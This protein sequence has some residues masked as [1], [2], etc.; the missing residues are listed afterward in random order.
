[1]KQTVTKSA[2]IDAFRNAGREDNF[3]YEGLCALFDW[4]EE[5]GEDTGQE[6][7]LDVIALCCEFSE[8]GSALEACENYDF[9]PDEDDDEDDQEDEAL[10]WLRQRTAT[11]TFPGGI[12]IQD[13]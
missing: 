2:F 7:E 6:V 4:L 8:Y 10:D 13:F 3:S 12:I 5:L 9:E 1:M 11:I